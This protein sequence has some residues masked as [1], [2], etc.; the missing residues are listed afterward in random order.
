MARIVSSEVMCMK[1]RMVMA[2]LAAGGMFLLI[3]DA[4]TALGGAAEGVELC[5]RVA[6][7][8]LLPFFVL[9]MVLT[10]SLTG[11]NLPFLRPLG[12]ACG[13]PAGAESLLL[14]GLLGGYPVGAQ[15]TAAAYRSGQ[16]PKKTA[17]RML[18]FCSNAGPAFLFGIVAAK[19]EDTWIPWAL[20]GIHMLAAV[21]T[22]ILLPGKEAT[23]AE[24]KQQKPLTLQAALGRSTTVMAGV[25]GWIVLFRIL[26]AFLKRWFLWLLPPSGQVMVMGLLELTNGCCALDLIEHTGPRIL[27]AS[28]LLAFGGLCVTMQT[29]SATAGLGLG[30]YLLGKLVQTGLSLALS[31]A[32]QLFLPA[33]ER[34]AIPAAVTAV[35]PVA[36]AIFAVFLR[37]SEKKSSIRAKLVV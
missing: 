4:P 32:L 3:L 20:W 18:G 24:T 35:L 7:P 11:T 8:S 21:L 12:R 14:V 37:E 19:F 15:V 34:V 1:R 30:A 27:A 26:I 13:I 9:S 36:L 2:L 28:T 5:L 22:G 23:E 6:V 31:F 17:A 16:L 10:S 29:A 33:E 25:C